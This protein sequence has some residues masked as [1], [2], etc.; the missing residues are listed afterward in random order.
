MKGQFTTLLKRELWEHRSLWIAPLVVAGI[1][2]IVSILGAIAA[3]VH[4][5]LSENVK[6]GSLGRGDN[7]PVLSSLLGMSGP[8]FMVSCI[9]IVV[10]LLDCLYAERKDRSILFWKSLPVSDTLAVL[11]KFTLAMVIVPL[12]VYALTVACHTFMGIV[13]SIGVP[14]INKLAGVGPGDW[15]HAQ[16]RF[17]GIIVA[18]LLWYAPIGAW[19]MLASVGSRRA[20]ILW[21]AMPPVA[22]GVIE[23]IF[24]D[25]RFVWRFLGQ[26]FQ[27]RGDFWHATTQP[28]LWLGLVAAAGILYMVIRLRRYRDDT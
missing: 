2:V 3:G 7:N 14:G 20:P 22:L 5:D 1:F 8:L 26:R 21:A 16:A 15:I 19:F 10:Y 17:L 9:T 4:F 6:M 25:S 27:P 11:S 13:L 12:A 18:T 24:L 23:S 28:G